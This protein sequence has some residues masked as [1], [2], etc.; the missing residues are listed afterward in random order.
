MDF[1]SNLPLIPMRKGKGQEG[2]QAQI[3]E[4]QKYAYEL[5]D[6]TATRE[7]NQKFIDRNVSLVLGPCSGLVALDIDYTMSYE[8]TLKALPEDVPRSPLGKF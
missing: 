2:K 4:W 3:K 8:E 1:K 5:P 6:E 7:W